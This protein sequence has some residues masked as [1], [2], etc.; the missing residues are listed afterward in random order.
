MLYFFYDLANL[1]DAGDPLSLTEIA[2]IGPSDD[3]EVR[4][5]IQKEGARNYLCR[6]DFKGGFDVAARIAALANR[7]AEKQPDGK[8][9][10]Q[11]YLPT[12]AGSHQSPRYDVIRVPQV[13]AP[14]SYSFNGDTYPD[15]HVTYVTPGTC[16][17][18]RTSGDENHPDGHTYYRRKLSGAW[19]QKGGTWSLVQGHRYEQNPEL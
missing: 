5:R 11:V 7:W 10:A 16:R 18:I 8:V 6:W 12:D 14:C 3:P 4:R 15:G 19:I 9:G 13:G 17:I 2:Y 1:P